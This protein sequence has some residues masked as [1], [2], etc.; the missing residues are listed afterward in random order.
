MECYSEEIVAIFVD[1]ELGADEARLLRD[2]LATCQRCRHL[3]DGLRAENRLLSESLQELPGKESVPKS[4]SRLPRPLAWSDAAIATAVL[5]LASTVALWIDGLNLPQAIEWLNPFS[6]SG[7]TNLIFNLSYYVAQ[8]GTAMLADYAAMVGKIFVLLLLGGGALLLARRWRL[9]QPGLRLLT[10]LLALSAPG[11]A[12]DYRHT[13][14]ITIAASETVDDTLLA[15]GNSVRVDG[16]IN[17]DLLAFGGT[18][19]VRGTIKGDLISFAQR[20]VVNGT[21]QGNI[22][23]ASKS[24]DLEGQLVHSLYA[25]GQSL[26]VND[27][28]RV[29]NGIIAAAGDVSL[30]GEVNRSVTIAVGNNADVSGSIGRE[31]TMA[32]EGLNL[33]STSRI[34]GN[35][36]VHVDDRKKVHIADGATIGGTRDIQER[37][38]RSH[39]TRPAFY[40]YQ[41][42]WLAAAMLVGWLGLVLAPRFFQ[43]TTRVV[44]NGWRSLALGLGVLAGTPVA[45]LVIALTLVGLPLSLILLAAY[46]VAIYM[47][48]IWVAAFLGR[49]LLKPV[50]EANS[51]WLLAL[52]VGLVIL[53]IVGHVPYLGG[54]VYFGVICLGLGALAWQLYVVSR[55]ATTA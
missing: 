19:E 43:A 11:L 17:G 13:E 24:F 37:V 44:G 34:G 1:G 28:G 16:V 38:R 3:L 49:R 47:A 5:A 31:L 14:T 22:F 9:R 30:D 10:V 15:S 2:H 36:T 18:V 26:R 7:R 51:D 55:A 23:N 53:T 48:K 41:A 52:L 27:R 45:M 25:L 21:V 46:L 40:V 39:F 29:G 4:L 12:L 50:G 35:L 8:G 42:V 33:T 54:L 32:G 20:T 6:L